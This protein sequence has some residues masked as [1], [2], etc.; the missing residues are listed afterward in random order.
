MQLMQHSK[1]ISKEIL[2]AKANVLALF[3]IIVKGKTLK[4]KNTG[5]YYL[6]LWDYK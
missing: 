5:P 1:T 2:M 6:F 4:R 3:I